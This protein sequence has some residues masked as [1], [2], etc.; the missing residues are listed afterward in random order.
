MPIIERSNTILSTPNPGYATA[1]APTAPVNAVQ[2]VSIT[3]TPTGGTFTLTYEGRTTAPIAYNATAIAV[4]TALFA[5]DVFDSPDIVASGG[6]LP[7]T[8]VVLTFGGN[9]AGMPVSAFTANGSGLTGGTS[10]AV[11]VAQTTAGVAAS[12][13][14]APVGC[15]L[16]DTTNGKIYV[17]TGTA[18][19]PT[20]TVVGSQT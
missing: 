10:P 15:L 8:P 4:R 12:G 19:S 7:T 6:A 2:T 11:S 14:G 3:G 20:W 18:L 1:G 17:N 9:Y 13:R 16:T 5:L